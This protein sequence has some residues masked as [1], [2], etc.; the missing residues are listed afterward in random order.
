VL[1]KKVFSSWDR[2]QVPYP[3]TKGM[4]VWGDPI[5]VDPHLGKEDL[6]E[7]RVELQRVLNALTEHA[8]VAVQ[9]SDPLA[10]FLLSLSQSSPSIHE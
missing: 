8:D 2:F 9:Q 6:V 4:F 1:K 10:S 7:Q 3:W 5:W